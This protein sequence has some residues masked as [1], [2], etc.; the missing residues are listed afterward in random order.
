MFNHS[1]LQLHVPHSA[2]T[3]ISAMYKSKIVT[4]SRVPMLHS[5]FGGCGGSRG[6]DEI[7]SAMVA[8]GVRQPIFDNALRTISANL[9]W[10]G[11]F[12]PKGTPSSQ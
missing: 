6:S 11:I 1:I 9:T 10:N 12:V 3:C 5:E 4:D 8:Q 7:E 2:L